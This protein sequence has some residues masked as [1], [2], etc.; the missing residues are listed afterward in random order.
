M[1]ALLGLIILAAAITSF[2]CFILVLIKLFGDKGVGWGIFGIFCSIYTFIWGWQ[3]IDRYNIKN[4]M[5][6]WSAMIGVNLVLRILA[7]VA[8]NSQGS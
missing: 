6:L 4:I 7:I 5:V 8:V 1:D 2:V 3:N